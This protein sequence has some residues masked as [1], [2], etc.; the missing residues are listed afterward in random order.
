MRMLISMFV[1]VGITGHVSATTLT[2]YCEG[3]TRGPDIVDS[4]STKI[5]ELDTGTKRIQQV[6]PSP[7]ACFLGKN[8]STK[9]H[10]YEDTTDFSCV[11]EFAESYLKLSRYNLKL[12]EITRFIGK[13]GEKDTFWWGEF[14][15]EEKQRRF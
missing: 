2:L 15:C 6:S 11:S 14:T 3:V 4:P 8:R 7:T 5:I 9:T 10:L 12:E 1:F 13:N